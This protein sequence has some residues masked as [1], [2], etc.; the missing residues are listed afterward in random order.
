[1]SALPWPRQRPRRR[2]RRSGVNSKSIILGLSVSKEAR[3]WVWPKQAQQHRAASGTYHPRRH[4]PCR[5]DLASPT[6][7]S[8]PHDLP[9]PQLAPAS[10][11]QPLTAAH[12]RPARAELIGQE[13]DVV[14]PTR[15]ETSTIE[16]M[17][18][19]SSPVM[20]AQPSPRPLPCVPLTSSD[21]SATAAYR[22]VWPYCLS[23]RR[24]R[25]GP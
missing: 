21:M 3:P 16:V 1:M 22:P 12:R 6:M 17:H 18:G 7:F 9:D 15:L 24:L 11:A 25:Q 4:R 8:A 19:P 10:I 14:L 13:C 23:L 20:P 5:I 2:P